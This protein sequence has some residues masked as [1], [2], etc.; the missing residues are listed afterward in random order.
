[1]KARVF[2]L[3]FI[4]A[5]LGL[6][7]HS[8]GETEVDLCQ[9]VVQV[10]KPSDNEDIS[11]D[12]LFFVRLEKTDSSLLGTIS[13]VE[14]FE[15]RI[16]VKDMLISKGIYIFD[17]KGNFIC[18][19]TVMGQGPQEFITLSDF[20]IDEKK[21]QLVVLD[22]YA[23]TMTFFDL[24]GE[25]ID[26]K[27]I[28][29]TGEYFTILPDGKYV[30]FSDSSV[31]E[32]KNTV[33]G[34]DEDFNILCTYYG[35]EQNHNFIL[36]VPTRLS[37]NEQGVVMFS[38]PY[39]N[40]VYRVSDTSFVP[41]YCLKY[42]FGMPI[43]HEEALKVTPFEMSTIL[44][45][46]GYVLNKGNFIENQMY[47]KMDFFY[48]GGPGELY[49]FFYEKATGKSK[50]VKSQMKKNPLKELI[51]D[52]KGSQGDYFIATFDPAR[53]DNLGLDTTSTISSIVKDSLL[54]IDREE[55]PILV[56]YSLKPFGNDEDKS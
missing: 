14:V 31:I 40:K 23:R 15:D 32:G 37:T 53:L 4:G 9:E 36:G 3:L 49:A 13:S 25:F 50:T 39:D 51:F 55:N 27:R 34:T 52:V 18:R 28:D 19:P 54:S 16:F 35:V 44:A 6:G 43:P 47:W 20:K 45:K 33:L 17:E 12:S 42:S 24:D 7:C 1:M 29:F 30:F 8:G 48:N 38:P 26:R 2:F 41:A 46:K 10:F 22:R 11:V 5:S 56:F 21:K